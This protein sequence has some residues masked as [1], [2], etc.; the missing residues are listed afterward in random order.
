V[1]EKRQGLK[2][3]CL[4]EIAF[5]NGWITAEDVLRIAEPMKKNQYGQ[6]LQQL[7]SRK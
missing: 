7:V 6:Y 2:I 3:S 5:H 4:E 1:L